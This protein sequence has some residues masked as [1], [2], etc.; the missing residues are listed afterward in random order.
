MTFAVTFFVVFIG[1]LLLWCV[2]KVIITLL[3][4]DSL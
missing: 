4:K 2:A 3:G 1:G